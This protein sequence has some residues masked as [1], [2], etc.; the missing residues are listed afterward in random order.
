MKKTGFVSAKKLSKLQKNFDDQVSKLSETGR[1]RAL[2]V[3]AEVDEAFNQMAGELDEE[4]AIE[5]RLRAASGL[6]H[7]DAK[8]V[9]ANMKD[10]PVGKIKMIHGK[11]WVLTPFN[12]V[13]EAQVYMDM[14][15]QRFL[16]L[17]SAPIE[18]ELDKLKTYIRAYT[19][20]GFLDLIRL[21]FKRLL[22]RG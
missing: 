16:E 20:L 2:A 4:V 21:A 3:K 15:Q 12:T 10:L 5:N 22:K 14:L 11:I 6:H 9:I 18:E 19:K 8:D 13:V 1:K 7:E 17:T